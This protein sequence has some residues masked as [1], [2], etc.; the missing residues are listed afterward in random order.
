MLVCVCFVQFAHET[1]GAARTRLSLRPLMEEGGTF[2]GKLRA[3]H[4]ARSRKHALIEQGI[5]TTSSRPICA[6]A[7]QEPGPIR[8]SLSVRAL[9]LDILRNMTAAAYGSRRSPGRRC[10]MGKAKRAQHISYSKSPP[11][12]LAVVP[13]SRNALMTFLPI[14]HLCTSSGPSTSRCERTWVYHLASGV[15]WLKPSAP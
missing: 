8:R 11:A 14:F 4:A 5:S 7:H 9:A 6:I 10:R 15:S 2:L 3:N 12:A 13:C 1:A